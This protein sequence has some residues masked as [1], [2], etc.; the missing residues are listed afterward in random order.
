ME[1]L[2]SKFTFD[3]KFTKE[4]KDFLVN[5]TQNIANIESYFGISKTKNSLILE[6]PKLSDIKYFCDISLKKITQDYSIKI[7]ESWLNFTMPSEIQESH[8]Y[9]SS[10]FTGIFYINASAKF[11][12]IVFSQIDE[13]IN[14]S[15]GDLIIFPSNLFYHTPKN[16]GN[17]LKISLTFTTY[18]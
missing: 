17:D 4:E 15:R 16:L 5:Y 11:H 14:T 3:R 6:Q 1:S 10:L 7:K 13:K 12:S 9:P 2:I 8:N 18:K